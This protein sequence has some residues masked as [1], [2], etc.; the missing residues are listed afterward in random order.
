MT[1]F[2]K[3][4]ASL[5]VMLSTCLGEQ[6]A[7]A[8]HLAPCHQQGKHLA[9]CSHDRLCIQREQICDGRKDCAEGEDETPA[10]CATWPCVTGVRCKESDTCLRDPAMMLCSDEKSMCEDGS[11]KSYCLQRIFTGCFANTSLGI[12]I[13]NCNSCFCEL[14]N[15]TNPSRREAM[16]YKSGKSRSS[17]TRVMGRIC[18]E[19]SGSLFCDG[20]NDCLFGEDEDPELCYKKAD[21]VHEQNKSH[22]IRHIEQETFDMRDSDIDID[23]ATFKMI[24]VIVIFTGSCVGV[25][26]FSLI[27]IVMVKQI[28]VSKKTL[29]V[30]P[31]PPSNHQVLKKTY[32]EYGPTPKSP[33]MLKDPEWTLK[34]I[35]IVKELGKGFY[36]KVY[37]AQDV[38][39][40]F[41][42]LKTIDNQKTNSSEECIS[43]EIEILSGMASHLNIVKI[44]GFNKDEKLVVMEYCFNG[45]LKDY[46]SRYRDY[47]TDEINPETKELCN[48]AVFPFKGETESEN[49][50]THGENSS[51]SDEENKT[52]NETE[53]RSLIKTRR[54]LYWSYQISKGLKFLSD[55]GIVHR[56]IALRNML[57]TNNDVVKIA[58]FGL[59]VSALSDV[60]SKTVPQYWNQSNKPQPYQWMAIESLVANIYSQAS[61]VWSFGITMWEL[62]TLGGEPYGRISP[63]ELSKML[64]MGRR[65]D[66]C[67]LAPRTLNILLQYCWLGDPS[68]RPNFEN[69]SFEL[70]KFMNHADQQ[71]YDDRSSL[72]STIADCG[73]YV[74]LNEDATGT[75]TSSTGTGSKS[76]T[77]S[78]TISK[79]SEISFL[80]SSQSSRVPSP[81]T[82][83]ASYWWNYKIINGSEPQMFS[84]VYHQNNHPGPQ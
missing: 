41:V 44:I 4:I 68:Q 34:R 30:P 6:N 25:L 49:F 26:V 43:N 27:I 7:L 1:S 28:K 10:M 59:A 54:L 71:S 83:R 72:Y 51:E 58:D 3:V 62:F 75:G 66:D 73:A 29:Q 8:Q 14:R 39:N 15:K 35:S 42:A 16:V 76:S 11:D 17:G 80:P 61:D 57:L 74:K 53:N 24:V 69:I 55:I 40:G 78:R 23:K 46:I 21:T 52:R 67:S 64:Q 31:E 12:K 79:C 5:L 70:S 48:V 37:L 33:V 9:Q 84:S 36:S 65:L 77:R 32:N 82:P 22:E 60:K 47:Y 18:M 13:I 2:P 63:V 56:D 45:N 50:L 20:S 81:K 38:Q 19:R